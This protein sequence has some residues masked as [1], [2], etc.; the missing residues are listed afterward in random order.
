MNAVTGGPAAA[1]DLF[2]EDFGSLEQLGAEVLPDNLQAAVGT[3]SSAGSFGS[4]S[5]FGGC[6]GCFSS[7]STASTAG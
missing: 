1:L 5:T 6:V 7:G 2:L 3:L 4:F